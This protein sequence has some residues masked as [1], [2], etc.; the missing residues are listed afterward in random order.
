M[1]SINGFTQINDLVYG[2]E[3]DRVVRA[4]EKNG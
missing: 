3:E 4:D 1:R 2:C